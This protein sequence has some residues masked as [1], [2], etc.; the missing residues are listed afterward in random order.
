MPSCASGTDFD[1]EVAAGQQ[2]PLGL[3]Q[4]TGMWLRDRSG[5][6]RHREVDLVERIAQQDERLDRNRAERRWRPEVR[7]DPAEPQ[8][9]VREF[10]F[11]PKPLSDIARNSPAAV[12]APTK[13]LHRLLSTNGGTPVRRRNQLSQWWDLAR[14]VSRQACKLDQPARRPDVRRPQ[15]R[16]QRQ[17]LK[18]ISRVPPAWENRVSRAARTWAAG[19]ATRAVTAVSGSRR[20]APS[21]PMQ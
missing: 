20:T 6:R 21:T 12:R 8:Q 16:R 19:A 5:R 9:V 1:V 3:S 18:G 10:G 15:S 13:T 11:A 4:S 2:T 14:S 7:R 17:T